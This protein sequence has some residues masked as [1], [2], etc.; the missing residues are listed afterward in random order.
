MAEEPKSAAETRE[1]KFV[2]VPLGSDAKKIGQVVG[3]ETCRQILD[4]LTTQP[5]SASQVAEKL[6]PPLTTVQ[7]DVEKLLG[8]GL[9]RVER[10][11]RT[12]KMREMK[13][14]GPVRKLIV[15]VPEALT[16]EQ[17]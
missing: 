1:E 2:I 9:I 6:G 11:A 15:V 17:Q 14:Y 13:I 10:V 16:G 5:M 12:E 3:S 8:A 4:A 7:Y